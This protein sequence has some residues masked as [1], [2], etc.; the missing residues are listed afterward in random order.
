MKLVTSESVGIGHPDKICDQISDAVL[1]ECLRQDP[2]SRVACETFITRGLVIVGGEITTKGYVDIDS[3]AR[4]VIKDAGYTGPEFK[5]DFKTCAVLNTINKQ[6]PDISMGVD[7]GGAGD[8]GVMVGYAT[9]ETPTYMPMSLHWAHRLVERLKL[10]RETRI[11]NLGPD[12]KSQVVVSVSPEGKREIKEVLIATQHL[13]DDDNLHQ[14]VEDL[15]LEEMGALIDRS[16]IKVNPTGRFVEAGPAAD[17]GLTGRKIIVDTYGGIAP[18]GGGAFS[19]KDPTKVDRS[20]A[21]MARYIAKNLV[22]AGVAENITIHLAY[23]IGEA[24]PVS[25]SVVQKGRLNVEQSLNISDEALIKLVEHVFKLRPKDIIDYFQ[26]KNP[27]YFKTA[28]FGHFGRWD[29]PWEK[30]DKIQEINDYV[31]NLG[32]NA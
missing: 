10:V 25:I 11:S 22:A 16:R 2:D 12:C 23:A 4:K 13:V 26:L 5:F 17:T 8:Q 30:V 14:F 31:S 6:S 18:H 3:I 27:I 20:G 15:V 7:R 28:C 32:E 19:G 1:D 24:D 21:Y 9:N 29:F